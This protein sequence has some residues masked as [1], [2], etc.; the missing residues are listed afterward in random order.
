MNQNPTLDTLLS[1]R[2]I[3]RFEETPIPDGDVRLAVA[4][5]QQASTSS[6]VQ[7]YSLLRIRDADRLAKLVELTGGQA[8]V[9]RC[10]AFFVVCGDTRRHRLL[11]ERAELPYETR[12]EG[13]LV[14]AIDATLFAQNLCVAFESMGYGICYIGGL[15]NDLAAVQ[16][17]LRFPRGV[18][19][20]FGLCV[21]KPAEDPARRPRLAPEAV[22][23]E[24]HYPDDETLLA[25]VRDYDASMREYY[26]A[27]GAAAASWSE[28]I[29]A[30]FRQAYRTSVAD[31]YRD[32]G[33][34]LT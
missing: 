19:P 24:E 26:A 11:A 22:L 16:K 21:G 5:G 28:K 34:D 29:E 7:A 23:F 30:Q 20:L 25:G 9:A 13:F 15:R 10:G 2:S 12:L 32:Q 17:L 8:K 18:Y 14:A 3:R 4:A 27:R 1:H 33:A 31:Y 6:N